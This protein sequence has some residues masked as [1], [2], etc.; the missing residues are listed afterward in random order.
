VT[1]LSRLGKQIEEVVDALNDIGV[2]FALI[3]GLALASHK[4]VRATRDIDFL[5]DFDDAESIDGA[6]SKLGYRCAHRSENAGNYLRTDERVDFLY[7]SRPAARRL[8]AGAP[9]LKTAFGELRVVSL[10]GMIGFKLQGFVND[11]RRTQDLEDIRA[12]MRANRAELNMPEVRE[13]FKLF[14]R[15]ALLQEVLD[16]LP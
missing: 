2:R 5:T 16:D 13:Y 10:E 4:V 8:L 3:G 11:P 7:A 1:T 6:L 12:L 15:E 14:D 9:E